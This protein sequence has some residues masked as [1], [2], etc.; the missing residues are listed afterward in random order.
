[1]DL[2]MDLK[3][4]KPEQINQR[5]LCNSILCDCIYVLTNMYKDLRFIQALWSLKL[6]DQEFNNETDLI[7]KIV[8]RFQEEPINTI[9][10]IRPEIERLLEKYTDNKVKSVIINKLN[11]VDA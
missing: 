1:M 6:I 5:Y 11:Q 7:P 8:D 4:M 3:K 10:R 2:D 9:K